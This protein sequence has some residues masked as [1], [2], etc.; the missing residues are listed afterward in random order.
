MIFIS[1]LIQYSD[2]DFTTTASWYYSDCTAGTNLSENF[3][4]TSSSAVFLASTAYYLRIE[5]TSTALKTTTYNITVAA[6]GN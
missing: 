2:S 1:Y 3:T 5:G 6:E 4:G